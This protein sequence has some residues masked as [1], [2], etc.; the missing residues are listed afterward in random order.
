VCSFSNVF[1]TP[2]SPP[3]SRAPTLMHAH[4]HTQHHA[5][6]KNGFYI[7]HVIRSK[8][9]HFCPLPSFEAFFLSQ[10]VQ[11]N[12]NMPSYITSIN[13]AQRLDSRG[14]P[15]VQV[16]LTTDKGT[17]HILTKLNFG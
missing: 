17:P 16:R 15:T 7:S 4:F 8:C 14:N 12:S 9:F 6:S 10:Q 5:T 11:Q 13:A 1:I 3:T 2:L